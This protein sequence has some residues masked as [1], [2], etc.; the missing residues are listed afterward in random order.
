MADT[1]KYESV[2]KMTKSHQE[3]EGVSVRDTLHIRVQEIRDIS[4]MER[5]KMIFKQYMTPKIIAVLWIWFG[6]QFV[7]A[8]MLG[9]NPTT[10]AWRRIFILSQENL[11]SIA[12]FT[13]IIGHGSVPHILINSLVFYGFGLQAEQVLKDYKYLLFFVASGVTASLVQIGIPTIFS[14]GG[15]A[16]VG[17]SG[18]ISA[19]I[20]I[21]AVKNP[22]ETVY[23]LFFIPIKMWK[24]I[25]LFAVGSTAAVVIW[26]AG[27]GG[28]GHIAHVT[29]I[30]FGVIA[31]LLLSG[32]MSST[33]DLKHLDFN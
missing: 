14:L 7:I 15:P 25:A 19:V 33:I 2:D 31:G 18:A 1:D 5:Q 10:E 29:G 32:K 27:A 11:F 24:G 20:G 6:V 21:V 22:N 8:P 9:L 12:L 13:N 23:L 30:V 28:L 4:F 26:G 16:I 17:A 3:S